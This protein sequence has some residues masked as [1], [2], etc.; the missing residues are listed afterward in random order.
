MTPKPNFDGSRTF[1]R[2]WD[3]NTPGSGGKK[4]SVPLLPAAK[5]LAAHLRPPFQRLTLGQMSQCSCGKISRENRTVRVSQVF[6]R[7]TF[8]LSSC[9]FDLCNSLGGE[10]AKATATSISIHSRRI[11]RRLRGTLSKPTG[12]LP[13]TAVSTAISPASFAFTTHHPTPHFWGTSSTP[14]SFF[15]QRFFPKTARIPFGRI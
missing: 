14:T 5:R 13:P 9:T 8:W 3:N 15:R 4:K 7:L 1:R 10:C 11:E 6:R 12:F 2:F